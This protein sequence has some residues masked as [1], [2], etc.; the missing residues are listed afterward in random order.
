M[1]EPANVS[2]SVWATGP[3]TN[4]EDRVVRGS[5]FGSDPG[6]CRLGYREAK[7]PQE[8]NGMLGLRCVLDA[9]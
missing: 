4:T 9:Q 1:P 6:T 7:E 8:H 5:C 2:L 3:T